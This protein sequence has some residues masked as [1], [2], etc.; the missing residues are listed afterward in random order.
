MAKLTRQTFKQFAVNANPASD[1][2][3]FGSLAAGSPTFSA[4]VTTI[5]SLTAWITGWAAE[6]V[7]TNRPALEDQNAVDFVYAYM[8]AYLFQAGIAEYDSGTTYYTNSIVQIAGQLFISLQDSNIG[9]TPS[10]SPTF[11][12]SGIPGAE[13]AGVIKQ[14]AGSVAP[15]GYLICD[16][17][18]ISRSTYAALFAICGTI[19]GAG[20]G[21]TTFNIPDLRTRIPVGYSLGDDTFGTLG[22]S[23]GEKKHQLTTPELASH[24]H[25]GIPIESPAN[26]LGGSPA[27]WRIDSATTANTQST[28]GDTPHNNL[29]PYLTIN[30]II[31]T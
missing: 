27:Q 4:S 9:N 19:Y 10:T 28:G 26:I 15:T 7:A 16:G 22:N 12:Q 2:G 29:Q 13:A 18:A 21:T 31:K 3:V 11:W 1:I 23:G 6:T 14:Y 30:H 8:I 17:S 5:Q 25:G 24:V 20:N